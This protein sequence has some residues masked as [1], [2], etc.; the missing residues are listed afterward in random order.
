MMAVLG[1][2][3]ARRENFSEWSAR[4]EFVCNEFPTFSLKRMFSNSL[5]K[6]PCRGI[7]FSSFK[8]IFVHRIHVLIEC[9]FCQPSKFNCVLKANQTS[10]QNSPTRFFRER[11]QE[12]DVFR[13]LP[14]NSDR[15]R[16]RFVDRNWALYSI[17]VNIFTA[18]DY[19]FVIYNS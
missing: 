9:M 1:C 10:N 16:S 3:P 11:C 4:F 5:A 17:H 13:F 15:K 7:F 19:I 2:L 12:H 8:S 18:N 6:N 14:F